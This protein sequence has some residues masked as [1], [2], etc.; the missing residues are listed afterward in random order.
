M[1]YLNVQ[2]TQFVC[3]LF[4]IPLETNFFHAVEGHPQ[5]KIFRLFEFNNL[6]VEL[7]NQIIIILMINLKQIISQV[8]GNQEFK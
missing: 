5:K 2:N 8:F 1:W 6:K 3:K 4:L 7:C